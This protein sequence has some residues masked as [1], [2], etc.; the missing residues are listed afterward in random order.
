M[1]TQTASTAARATVPDVRALVDRLSLIEAELATIDAKAL[2]K[3]SDDIKRTLREHIASAGY[4]SEESVF[5]LGTIAEVEFGPCET[6]RVV[7]D[8]KALKK[9]LGA[10]LYD[11]LAK[12]SMRD[13]RQYISDQR[14]NSVI[15]EY[16]GNR[17]VRSVKV[18][19]Q[20]LH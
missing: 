10:A 12:F 17:K 6:E 19:E 14:I 3:E 9:M 16:Y 7:E 15:K 4:N 2:I 13:L 1:K 5:L 18:L 11:K 20:P 8:K